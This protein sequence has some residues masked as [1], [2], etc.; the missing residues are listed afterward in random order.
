M[1]DVKLEDKSIRSKRGKKSRAAGARFEL[2]VRKD[3]EKNGWT[4]A[5][6]TNQIEFE[7]TGK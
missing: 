7:E 4:V 6:W 2:K 5:K 1:E 3:L